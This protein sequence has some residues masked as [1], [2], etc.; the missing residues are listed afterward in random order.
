[1]RKTL[2]DIRNSMQFKEVV[3][4]FLLTELFMLVSLVSYTRFTTTEITIS[5]GGVMETHAIRVSYYGFPFEMLGVLN[6]FGMME[7]YYVSLAGHGLVQI[8]WRGIFTNFVLYFLLAFLIVYLS[9]RFIGS[10]R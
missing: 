1:M 8:V 5:I 7:N 10:R 2:E 6:P 9:K 3:F 4:S